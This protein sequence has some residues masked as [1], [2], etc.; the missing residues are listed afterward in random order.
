MSFISDDWM[1]ERPSNKYF[2]GQFLN[3][4]A[5]VKQYN[6]VPLRIFVGD[7]VATAVPDVNSSPR[8][9]FIENY[10]LVGNLSLNSRLQIVPKVL[11]HTLSLFRCLVDGKLSG[12]TSSFMRRVQNDK[13][14]FQLEAFRFM[15]AD[16]GLVCT[17]GCRSVRLNITC[18]RFNHVLL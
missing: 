8:Y 15:Q 11:T 13:L 7:C 1:F 4:E 12:S 17:L 9:S 16:S 3:L 14:Q 2:L 10:G 5:S 18:K 6:H